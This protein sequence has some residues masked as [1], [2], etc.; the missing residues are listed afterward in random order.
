M[1]QFTRGL[2]SNIRSNRSN[3]YARVAFLDVILGGRKTMLVLVVSSGSGTC[4]EDFFK[5]RIAAGFAA[6]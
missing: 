3:K 6:R 1:D 4:L 2:A 5:P